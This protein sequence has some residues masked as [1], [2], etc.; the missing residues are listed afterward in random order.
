MSSNLNF[1]KR[2]VDGLMRLCFLS[3]ALLQAHWFSLQRRTNCQPPPARPLVTSAVEPQDSCSQVGLLGMFAS[4]PL[5]EFPG[6]LLR[7]GISLV[8]LGDI[9]QILM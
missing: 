3:D 2:S 8:L 7:S 9:A 1:L 4:D 5:P 6:L